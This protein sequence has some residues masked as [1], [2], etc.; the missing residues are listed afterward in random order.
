MY[1][2][3]GVRLTTLGADDVNIGHV[4]LVRAILQILILAYVQAQDWFYILLTFLSILITTSYLWPSRKFFVPFVMTFLMTMIMVSFPTSFLRAVI[5]PS[6]SYACIYS[7]LVVLHLFI[8]SSLIPATTVSLVH[9]NWSMGPDM[10]IIAVGHTAFTLVLLEVPIRHTI[11]GWHI[12][13]AILCEEAFVYLARA[14]V[15]L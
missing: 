8:P 12:I 1:I 14:L 4:C 3:I 2:T 13:P 6:L 15:T 5:L 11:E 9:F 10:L 7:A